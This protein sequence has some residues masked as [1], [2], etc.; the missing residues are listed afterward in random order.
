MKSTSDFEPTSTWIAEQETASVHKSWDK[1]RESAW[2][3]DNYLTCS[4]TKSLTSP[5][6]ISLSHL[7]S[8]RQWFTL[9]RGG[10]PQCEKPDGYRAFSWFGLFPFQRLH[11]QHPPTVCLTFPDAQI[12]YGAY[13]KLR[14]LKHFPLLKRIPTEHDP[15]PPAI[16]IRFE[17][18]V[19]FAGPEKVSLRGLLMTV[20]PGNADL[21]FRIWQVNFLFQ[22]F[23]ES[24]SSL[25]FLANRL[26]TI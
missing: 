2:V 5:G 20:F 4:K 8:R 13:R 11:G 25:M 7:R 24:S 15:E 22:P 3:H 10:I 21:W 17:G 18:H 1:F 19:R 12:A 9:R 14:L 23:F 16:K 6:S 26:G